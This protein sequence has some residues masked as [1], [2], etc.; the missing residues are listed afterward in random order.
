MQ[1][2][3]TDSSLSR[4]C[5]KN[6][7]TRDKVYTDLSNIL[8]LT[9]LHAPPFDFSGCVCGICM[10]E[11]VWWFQPKPHEIVPI[12]NIYWREQPTQEKNRL[13]LTENVQC[14]LTRQCFYEITTQFWMLSKKKYKDWIDK[15]AIFLSYFLVCRIDKFESGFGICLILIEPYARLWLCFCLF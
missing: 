5:F 3:Y 13:D 6:V 15:S 2:N 9:L 7:H 10:C 12:K 14:R 11:C 1:W 4:N 8:E